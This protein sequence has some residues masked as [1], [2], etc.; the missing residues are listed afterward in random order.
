MQ[1]QRVVITGMGAV[2]PIGIGLDEFWDGL[3]S[4]RNGVRRITHFDP[5]EYRSH[6]AA[7][8]KDFNAPEWVEK[9]I[10]DRFDR[11]SVFAIASSVMAFRDAG[12]DDFSF[13]APKC[14]VIMGSGIGGAQ[15]IQDGI[16]K[17]KEK[18]PSAISPFFIPSVIINMAASLISIR[19]GFKGALAAPSVACST[20]GN[21]IG[22][23][24]R[25]I[26]R[27]NAKIMVA[28]SGEAAV[29]PMPYAGFCALRAMSS[30]NDDVEHASR[31]FDKNRDGFIMG[32]GSGAVILEELEHA[33]ARGAKIY[34][35][36]I[37]YGNTADAF[38]YTAPHPEADGMIRVM[39]EAMEDAA[40]QP[41]QV[42]FVNAHGTSTPLNDKA[43]CLAMKKV[44]N[45]NHH[46]IKLTSIKSMIGHLLAG[47]GSVEFISTIMSIKEGIIPPTINTEEVDENCLMDIVLGKARKADIDI[48]INNNFGFGGGNASLI[49]KKYNSD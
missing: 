39:M 28:G 26:Q 25:M 5:Q 6:M 31:P 29:N 2:T 27:G 9:K 44:F 11:F 43:E 14:G 34:A 4:G 17:L 42:Q 22:E 16:I 8:V 37:G 7:E 49:L 32:E 40:I 38:H 1:E 23:A 46:K 45:H 47:A 33:K 3:I 10:I 20:G 30:R 18:G 41:E 35:E 36:L 19:L 13:D 24:Y 15:T 21:A 48:A 12:L